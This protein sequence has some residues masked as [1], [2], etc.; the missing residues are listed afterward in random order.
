LILSC[1]LAIAV[2]SSLVVFPKGALLSDFDLTMF[3]M[4]AGFLLI[5]TRGVTALSVL[6][7]STWI[8]NAAV[9]GGVLAV[10]LAANR[11]VERRGE[12]DP[13]RWFPLLAAAVV[14]LW[15]VEPSWLNRLPLLWRALAGGLLTAL[16]VGFAGVI[17]SSLVARARNLPAALASNLLGS[18]VGGCLEYLS[19]AL[20]LR[21]LALLALAIYLGALLSHRRQLAR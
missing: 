21:A 14:L 11:L 12:R 16:P 10:A 4:G 19:M 20:G 8:V 5:E 15:L 2:L 17:V 3:L 6:F 13:R 18:V 1:V 9:F 7:G